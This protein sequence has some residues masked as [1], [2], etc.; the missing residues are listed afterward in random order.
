MLILERRLD[1]RILIGDAIVIQ[2]V[3][4]NGDRVRLG[5]T[6]PGLP[7]DREEVRAMKEEAKA[8]EPAPS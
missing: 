4:I 1:Q 3:R 2:V 5:V 8:E 7:V 6:A